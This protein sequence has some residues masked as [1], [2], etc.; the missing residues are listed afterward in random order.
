MSFDVRAM[1]FLK[2]MSVLFLTTPLASA[3]DVIF[4]TA[5]RIYSTTQK[6]SSDIR[7]IDA[8]EI[9]KGASRTLPEILSKES[10]LTVVSS[11]QNG[12][13]ASLFLRGTDS[14]HTL[15]MIDGIVMNDPSN[16][17]RQ[18]DI[19][20]LS[21]NNIER[22]E[23]LKGSQGLAYGSNAIGGVLVITTKKASSKKATGG[24]YLEYGSFNTAQV[25]ADFQK[26]YAWANLSMGFDYMGTDGFSVANKTVNPMAEKDGAQKVGGNIGLNKKF[27]ED[28]ELDINVRYSH[29]KADLDKGGG[30][31]NDDPNDQQTEEELYSRVELTKN[32]NALNAQTKFSYN[33]SKH[34]RLLD[35]IYDSRHSDSRRTI[36]RGEINT[37]GANHTYYINEFLTQNLNLEFAH[38]KDQTNHFNQNLSGFLYHQFE[39]PSSIF[40]F[41]VRLD[42]NKSFNEHVTYKLAAGYKFTSALLKLAHSTGFRAPS[43]NQLYD[44]TY[45]NKNL[46]PE[47]SQST[48]LSL[49]NNW[50]KEIKTTTTLFST[51]I[52]NRLSYDPV[53][54]VNRNS[55]Q[56]SILGL[57]QTAGVD[58]VESLNQTLSFTL[59]KTKDLSTGKKLA[60]RPEFNLKN[61]FTF[62]YESKHN[63]AYELNYTGSRSDVDNSGL[64]VEMKSY[65]LSHL[66][67]RYLLNEHHEFYLKIRNVFN[68]EYEEIYGYGTGGRAFS[69]GAQYSF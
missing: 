51:R 3:E 1:P 25:G 41:G 8:K 31:G 29:N 38:E 54:F 6:S 69:F 50:S 65:L 27:T 44:P 24:H 56:A 53:T 22:I 48:D 23:I 35:V 66:N 21:L 19:G 7:I 58:W 34:H 4:I 62:L 59:L 55:N 57:E 26:K 15:V 63:L 10:D 64:G 42:H 46:T 49:E 28:Y 43:L 32:W 18:F 60:R 39:L 16:P 2:L 12:S 52:Q 17:N 20:R 67:Y 36:S 14:S 33:N 5:D 11:G 40:N 13:N 9:K 68:T 45:G 30:A 61:T 37:A 47:T